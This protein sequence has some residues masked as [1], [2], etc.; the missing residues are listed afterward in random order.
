MLL[1][2]LVFTG[3]DARRELY[4]RAVHLFIAPRL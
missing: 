4:A 1:G 2:D 3:I